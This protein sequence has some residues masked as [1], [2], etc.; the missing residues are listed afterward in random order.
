MNIELIPSLQFLQLFCETFHGVSSSTP[1]DFYTLV[2]SSED[3]LEIEFLESSDDGYFGYATQNSQNLLDVGLYKSSLNFKDYSVT[4]KVSLSQLPKDKSLSYVTVQGDQFLHRNSSSVD[5]KFGFFLDKSFAINILN[6]LFSEGLTLHYGYKVGG[7]DVITTKE[8]SLVTFDI[9]DVLSFVEGTVPIQVETLE[10]EYFPDL[11]ISVSSY[12]SDKFLEVSDSELNFIILTT[13]SVESPIVL[14]Y[15]YVGSTH[16]NE[17]QD[18]EPINVSFNSLFFD[19]VSINILFEHLK[20]KGSNTKAQIYVKGSL[21][22][23]PVF[24]ALDIYL[25]CFVDMTGSM[26]ESGVGG[27]LIESVAGLI[28]ELNQELIKDN[29][30]S[31]NYYI[32]I[33]T[34]PVSDRSIP[35]MFIPDSGFINYPDQKLDLDNFMDSLPLQSTSYSLMFNNYEMY[36]ELIYK[37]LTQRGILDT[38]PPLQVK[39]KYELNVFYSEEEQGTGT[40][41]IQ[42]VLPETLEVEKERHSAGSFSINTW[43]VEDLI[44]G[45]SVTLT[46][47]IV[48][49][50]PSNTDVTYI[51]L[52]GSNVTIEE[53]LADISGLD[54]KILF[55]ATYDDQPENAMSVAW[56]STVPYSSSNIQGW[57]DNAFSPAE[58]E[59][60]TLQK[61]FNEVTTL[62]EEFIVSTEES[63]I[64]RS[65]L[66]IQQ[67]LSVFNV[68]PSASQYS[69]LAIYIIP[70]GVDE[71][72]PTPLHGSI[73]LDIDT[74][75][76][77]LQPPIGFSYTYDDTTKVLNFT[78]PTTAGKVVRAWNPHEYAPMT[79]T[80][81]TVAEYYGDI[82]FYYD[83]LVTGNSQFGVVVD[84][85]AKLN[86]SL[87]GDWS[88]TVI[89]MWNSDVSKSNIASMLVTSINISNF[90]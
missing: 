42:V 48:G 54:R 68:W 64:C 84:S 32:R 52:S 11:S 17:A 22:L 26:W 59:L 80:H 1:E 40:F 13:A 50:L 25:T 14:F 20:P 58:T 53:T 38:L 89:N 61:P 71:D 29:V 35:T 57:V 73:G 4:S 46:L 81:P 45:E 7:L 72:T 30:R 66:D 55:L 9:E 10:T 70:L 24:K 5:P 3:A 86:W 85:W 34:T 6:S 83:V 90:T 51:K 12:Q 69:A 16:D 2:K 67:T 77:T 47:F 28:P 65:P 62:W 8:R 49:D 27:D 36:L 88:N 23:T 56:D 37:T 63:G 75:K 21:V 82:I 31:H 78:L 15:G 18:E 33:L 74:T 41:Q 87:V 43:N 76:Y 44:G 39:L 19:K 79:S 60:A